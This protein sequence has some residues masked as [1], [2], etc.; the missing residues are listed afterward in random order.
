MIVELKDA[1]FLFALFVIVLFLK[2]IN[3]LEKEIKSLGEGRWKD[4]ELLLK[5]IKV[6]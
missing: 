5:Q 1:I 3:D 6:K 2:E 4:R